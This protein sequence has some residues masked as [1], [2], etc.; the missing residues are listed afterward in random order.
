MKKIS[1][2]SVVLFLLYDSVIENPAVFNR[3]YG[4]M[5]VNPA[6]AVNGRITP[7][8]NRKSAQRHTIGSVDV[9]QSEDV[10]KN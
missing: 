1:I 10:K 3:Q 7:V 8:L 2:I 6:A 5:I 9:Q 4:I